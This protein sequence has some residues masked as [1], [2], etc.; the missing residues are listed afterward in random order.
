[1][2]HLYSD[3]T[4]P[5]SHTYSKKTIPPNLTTPCVKTIKTTYHL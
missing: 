3:T 4:P 1:M 5:Q 2:P